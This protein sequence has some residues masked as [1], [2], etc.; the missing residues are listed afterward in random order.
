MMKIPY[1]GD[2]QS[3]DVPGDN[4]QGIDEDLEAQPEEGGAENSS[5]D[6]GQDGADDN[7]GNG[8]QSGTLFSF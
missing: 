1:A 2:T 6:R 8:Q 4:Y 3:Y 5:G 7:A